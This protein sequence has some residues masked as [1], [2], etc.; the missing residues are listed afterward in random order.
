MTSETHIDFFIEDTIIDFY[1]QSN[2]VEEFY[3]K[4]Q[5]ITLLQ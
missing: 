5:V 4:Y 3:I 1:R 2:E